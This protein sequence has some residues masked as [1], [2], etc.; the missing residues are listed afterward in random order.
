MFNLK[1]V[2]YNVNGIRSSSGKK[3][4]KLFNY[5]H[6]LKAD[7]ICLQETHCIKEQEKIWQAE[8]GNKILFS[9]GTSAA[10]GVAIMFNRKFNPVLKKVIQDEEGQMLAI[11]MNLY[12]RGYAI[13]TVYAPNDDRVQF[14]VDVFTKI[15]LLEFE[16]LIFNGDLNT[17]LNV[18]LDLRGVEVAPTPK[19]GNSSMNLWKIT[20]CL[21]FGVSVMGIILELPLQGLNPT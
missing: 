15:E 2:T 1:L 16:Y 11:N 12:D 18:Q 13:A 20:S 4:R 21:M 6:T 7:V 9:N 10:R 17:V 19:P 14:F 8:W 3:R 5:L